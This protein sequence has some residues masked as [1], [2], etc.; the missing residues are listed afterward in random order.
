MT[1]ALIAE[2]P[3]QAK[4]FA[5]ALGGMKGTYQGDDYVIVSVRGHLYELVDPSLMVDPSLLNKYKSWELENLPWNETDL[6]W[7]RKPREG[8][9]ALLKE[10]K[11]ALSA[12]DDICI[13]VDHDPSGEG[14][15]LAWMVLDELKLHHK[16]FTRMEFTD[17]APAS[18]QKAFAAR[19]PIKSMMSEPAY[20][21]ADFRNRFDFLSMQFTRIATK[22]AGQRAVLRQGRLKSAMLVLVGDQLKAYNDYVKVPFFENRFKDEN[23]VVYSNPNEANFP[24]QALVP[25]SYG[26]SPVVLDSCTDKRQAP[27]RLLDLAG[28]SSILSTKGIK[29]A[30]V[31][32]TYQ[33]MYEAKIVSYPRTEDKTVTSEQFNELLPLID[34]IGA[35]V[36][37][38]TSLLTQRTPRKT[39]VKNSGAH[40]ANRPGPVVPVSLDALKAKY[41]PAAP[42]IYETLA[43]NY[44]AMLAE[45]YLYERQEGHVEKYP[46]FKGAVNVPKSLGYKAVFNA[47]DDGDDDE[48]TAGLGTNA[49]PFVHEGVNKR[50][51]HPSMKWLM[52]QLEKRD[53]GTGAT[54]TS[55]FADVT[56][57]KT[58]FPL[59]SE[60][61]GK[62]TMSEFGDMG[63]L[64]LPGTRIGDLGTTE[65][66]QAEMKAVAAGTKTADEALTIVAEW[67]RDDI[68]TMQT[69][70]AAM[71]KELNVAEIKTKEK[72]QGPWSKNGEVV[73][74][75]REWGANDHWGG[76]RFDDAECQKLLSGAVVSFD[77][78]SKKNSPYTAVGTLETGV[79]NEREFIGFKLDFDKH[80]PTAS[81]VPKIF[82]GHTFTD[83]ERKELEGGQKVPVAG[84]RSRKG[85]VFS[86]TISVGIKDGE[87]REC[88]ILEFG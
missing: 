88:L 47:A 62:I 11:V 8:A 43:K 20:L 10:L 35:V 63:Y 1:I 82:L 78:V 26:P 18:I 74:F 83:D 52:K 60:T 75:N 24:D 16:N 70:A 31:L 69:N 33:T 38:D 48:N 12:V 22:A 54:R 77:A 21:M 4:N 23:G 19:R 5:E 57:E 64:M 34:Q 3:S 13:G 68:K 45:D 37:A 81:P 67:V 58:K 59:L 71:R 85:N 14:D 15:L 2:K 51:E 44:L 55:T 50:P 66:V 61:R 28:L 39:H 65:F 46:T 41:G 87:T 27:P 29:A 17:E 30:L 49:D 72:F 25:N 32:K 7:K 76:H 6:D 73:S 36:G 56:N 86:A 40:G 53:V 79:F 84:L 9:T 80:D 42:L